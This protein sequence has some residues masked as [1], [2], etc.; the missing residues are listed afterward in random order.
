MVKVMINNR[1]N[2][3]KTDVNLLVILVPIALFASLNRP[4][5]GKRRE[6]EMAVGAEGENRETPRSNV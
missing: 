6:A 1:T 4:G 5:L 2:T 3:R